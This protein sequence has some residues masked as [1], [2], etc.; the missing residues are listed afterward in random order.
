MTTSGVRL[1]G[2]ATVR[3]RDGNIK[4]DEPSESQEGSNS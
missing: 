3:D 4:P 2:T 1:T